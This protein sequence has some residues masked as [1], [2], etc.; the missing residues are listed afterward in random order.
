MPVKHMLA[1]SAGEVVSYIYI[2]YFRNIIM[3]VS[4]MHS[5]CTDITLFF[6]EIKTV[7]FKLMKVINFNKCKWVKH[8]N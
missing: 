5:H 8:D 7:F 6:N 3:H 2:K 4:Y 1:A